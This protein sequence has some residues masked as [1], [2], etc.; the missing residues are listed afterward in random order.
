MC[1]R[2]LSSGADNIPE[3][4][5]DYNGDVSE[6]IVYS[7]ELSNTNR[8]SVESYLNIKYGITIPVASHDYYNQ[9]SFS[10]DIAGIGKNSVT[11][12]LNKDS[13]WSINSETILS[14]Y[15]P[16][17]L[18]DG[19]YLVWGNDGGSKTY[20]NTGIPGSVD[21]RMERV[22]RV[23]ETNEVGTVTLKFYM[24]GINQ[25]G[26]P[27]NASDI[28]LLV[29]NS[30]SD[31][32]DGSI[33]SATTYSNDT[34]YF[35]GVNLADND[36]FTVAVSG[37]D[38]PAGVGEDLELWL[39]GDCGVQK[40]GAVQA[41]IGDNILNWLDQSGYNRDMTN[42][43]GS[44]PVYSSISGDSAIDL[45]GGS[46]YLI[47]PSAFSGTGARTMIVVARPLSIANSTT[48]C[49]FA[50]SPNDASGN[51]YSMFFESPGGTNG[52][53]CRVGGNRVMN[54]TTSTTT[55]NIIVFQNGA[56][57]SVSATEFW[58]NGQAI[59]DQLFLSNSTLNTGSQ[60][61]I[62]GGLA[63]SGTLTPTASY[64]FNG[65]VYEVLVYSRE[66]SCLEQKQIELY[67]ADKY[68]ITVELFDES[69][70]GSDGLENDIAGI[71]KGHGDYSDINSV[72][73][74]GLTVSNVSYLNDAGDGLFVA[75]NN[76][77]QSQITDVPAGTTRRES[78]VWY[79]DYTSCNSNT[80]NVTLT[81]DLASLV[82]CGSSE[83]L[84]NASNYRLITSNTTSFSGATVVSGAS[85]IGNTLQFTVNV[86]SLTDLFFTVATT[87]ETSSPLWTSTSAPADIS[88][89]LQLWLKGDCGVEKSEGVLAS[90]TESVAFWRDQSG[91]SNDVS[92]DIGTAPTYTVSSGISG[93]DFSGGSNYLRGSPV[94]TGTEAR[95]T[96]VVT[97]A[98][99]LSAGNGNAI[100]SL[101]PNY[102]AGTGY[103]VS[104]ETPGGSNGMSVRVS[105]N[106]VM[107]Y[108]YPTGSR[109]ILSTQ[110]GAS[111]NVTDV[112]FFVNG[113][114][115][116]VEQS[117]A[118]AALNTNNS[119]VIL[120]GWSTNSDF[121]PEAS[122]DYDGSIH[123]LIVYNRELS[124]EERIQIEEYLATKY[125]IT[126]YYTES[127]EI[128]DNGINTDAVLIRDGATSATSS[129]LTIANSTFTTDCGDTLW[130]AHNNLSGITAKADEADMSGLAGTDVKRWARHWYG[131]FVS[132]ETDPGNVTL[133]FDLDDYPA[134]STL[135]VAGSDYRLITSASP[136]AYATTVSGPTINVGNNTVSFVVDVNEIQKK[137]FT[138]A[139]IDNSN[140]PL[141]VDLRHYE[142]KLNLNQVYVDWSTSSELNS[143]H[144]E[145]F[146]SANGEEWTLVSTVAGQ[147]TSNDRMDYQIID[148]DPYSGTSYYQLVQTDIDG[149]KSRYSIKRVVMSETVSNKEISIYPN[150]TT[151]YL[152]IEGDWSTKHEIYISNSSSKWISAQSF[153][154]SELKKR[155]ELNLSS[156]PP[157]MYFIKVVG[158]NHNQP[159]K[160]IKN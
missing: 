139:T 108:T 56:G 44:A 112:E 45:S 150:P 111:E 7:Q 29:D 33:T 26:T 107:N 60:G 141:P 105:G 119:G 16:N 89:G 78:R 133:T 134:S 48:N 153:M 130:Y 57:E 138:L 5:Y 132:N 2:R 110:A 121:I 129:A 117:S 31:F 160:V 36:H 92:N 59:T 142:V 84:A 116:I 109:A 113:E 63:V 136:W 49:A 46:S 155:I 148:N 124:C 79:S 27:V 127:E 9:S 35:T 47:G 90:N 65:Y 12:G 123:E 64:D 72:S 152:V 97:T 131:L 28:K 98:N 71:I 24:P 38:R 147:G 51:G 17:S 10:N 68:N 66:I 128:G 85:I 88:S 158:I 115:A 95:T 122:W 146:K 14:I 125:G 6:I 93:V 67:L 106:K 74:G 20:V 91:N 30:D 69:S 99:S 4:T 41:S 23:T 159:F 104:L 94:I 102:T 70:N 96:F 37:L 54:H 73:S 137:N 126:L 61:T 53:S 8:N 135:T 143:S 156:F 22:W 52:L 32:S 58:A 3:V 114:S 34:V 40:I 100:F 15:N 80:G 18:D 39:K 76:A 145:V 103:G 140:S 118:S 144:F 149:S 11:Q 62:L 82:T 25:C 13:A 120:G 157:G 1:Y 42:S 43:V 75:H 77:S 87:D 50:L 83:T 101:A 154:V 19:D 151:G 86:T 21:F 55:P 81:F